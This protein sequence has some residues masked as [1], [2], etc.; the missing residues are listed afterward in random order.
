[1]P[2]T[3]RTFREAPPGVHNSKTSPQVKHHELSIALFYFFHF[4]H[5]FDYFHF[6][7]YSN[8]RYKLALLALLEIWPPGGATCIRYRLSHQV[9]PLASVGNLVTRWCHLYF[10]KIKPPCGSTCISS[11]FSHQVA[12]LV[13]VQNLTTRWRHLSKFEI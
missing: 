10:F 12:P 5:F 13:L 1:M 7:D 9:A 2:L 8:I 11:K 3:L 4:I 6:F